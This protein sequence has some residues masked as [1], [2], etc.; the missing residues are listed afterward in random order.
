MDAHSEQLDCCFRAMM[1]LKAC[2]TAT[3]VVERSF[4]QSPHSRPATGRRFNLTLAGCAPRTTPQCDSVPASGPL[5]APHVA[6]AQIAGRRRGLGSAAPCSAISTV[7]RV[8]RG[9]FFGCRAAMRHDGDRNT[10]Y[11]SGGQL[12]PFSASTGTTDAHHAPVRSDAAANF[13]NKLAC[14]GIISSAH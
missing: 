1:L 9:P 14:R 8:A 5:C 4:V 13:Q 3:C 12:K 11:R 7:R 2:C 10:Q 6:V